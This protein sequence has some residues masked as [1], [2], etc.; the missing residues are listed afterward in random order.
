MWFIRWNH[1]PFRPLLR[2]R[3]TSDEWS[4]GMAGPASLLC[5]CEQRDYHKT[6]NCHKNKN[7]NQN[8]NKN[9]PK[10]ISETT[11]TQLL[12]HNQN[13]QQTSR[14]CLLHFPPLNKR[15]SQ[16]FHGRP[17]ATHHHI[18]DKHTFKASRK[19]LNHLTQWDTQTNEHSQYN[20]FLTNSTP[21]TNQRHKLTASFDKDHCTTHVVYWTLTPW[22]VR[23]Y[24]GWTWWTDSNQLH[25]F[26]E[27]YGWPSHL[28]ITQRNMT[29]ELRKLSSLLGVYNSGTSNSLITTTGTEHCTTQC[30]K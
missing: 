10:T 7:K 1:A 30:S 28:F 15:L 21:K 4:P 25:V 18:K 24:T 8:K 19:L 12:K 13:Q 26:D 2:R 9:K 27:N 11:L 29:H 5:Y 23:M 6:N 3:W 22:W 17:E 14:Q 16:S 20:L